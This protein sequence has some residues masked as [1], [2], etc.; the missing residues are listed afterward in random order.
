MKTQAGSRTKGMSW[1]LYQELWGHEKAPGSLWQLF[2]SSFLP[3]GNRIGW[4]QKPNL[5][6]GKSCSGLKVLPACSLQILTI[7]LTLLTL[8]T[9]SH[10]VWKGKQ[11][12]IFVEKKLSFCHWY[13]V[14]FWSL[15][16]QKFFFLFLFTPTSE[17]W[18]SVSM[19]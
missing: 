17:Q 6:G 15:P 8:T 9:W 18:W 16:S 7:N 12:K 3:P 13:N 2:L 5:G 14:K 19:L 11:R 10:S 1:A 4:H